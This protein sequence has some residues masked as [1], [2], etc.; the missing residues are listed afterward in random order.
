MAP[1]TKGKHSLDSTVSNVHKKIELV[2][3]DRANCEGTNEISSETGIC[4]W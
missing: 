4:G 3:V 1:H 2:K